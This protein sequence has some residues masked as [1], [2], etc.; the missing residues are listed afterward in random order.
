M[1]KRKYHLMRG[2]G[3]PACTMGRNARN[4]VGESLTLDA[5][6]GERGLNYF[7]DM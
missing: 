3:I 4:S 5:L 2:D 6:F 1:L 7:G